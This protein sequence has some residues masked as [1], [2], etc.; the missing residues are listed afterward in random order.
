MQCKYKQEV[1]F[2]KTPTYIILF[3]LRIAQVSWFFYFSTF[4]VTYE[5]PLFRSIA[6][7]KPFLRPS[8][9]QKVSLDL[10]MILCCSSIKPKKKNFSLAHHLCVTRNYTQK[11]NVTNSKIRGIR[12]AVFC[13]VKFCGF[14]EV[15]WYFTPKLWT[16]DT[17]SW[18]YTN[19]PPCSVS[20]SQSPD[21]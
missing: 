3:D 2:E 6:R 18:D 17:D 11:A 13:D 20:C 10:Q 5:T 4:S 16:T 19:H 1:M 8:E 21:D 12:D 9:L 7:M 15:P 14:Y